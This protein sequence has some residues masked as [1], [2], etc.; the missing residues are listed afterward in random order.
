MEPDEALLGG[1]ERG[2][3]REDIERVVEN[4]RAQDGTWSAGAPASYRSVRWRPDLARSDIPAVLHVHL[5]DRLRPYMLERLTAAFEAGHEIHVALPLP[6]LYDEELLCGIHEL[7][8]Q[9]HV[10]QSETLEC[11]QSAALLTVLCDRRVQVTPKARTLLA[12]KA[13]ELSQ[14]DGSAQLRGRR[15]EAAIAFL[16]GQVDDFDVVERNLRTDT[17]ELD[18]V[19]QQRATQGRVWSGLGAPLILVEAKNWKEPV[20][21]KEASAFRVKLDGRRGVVRLGLMFGATGFTS[22]A[23]DQELRFASDE[24]TIAFVRPEELDE[25]IRAE[26]GGDEYIETLVRRAMLR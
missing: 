17:E 25:W 3:E 6:R 24:L 11:A 2:P 4:I 10:I 22:D 1:P 9:I 13:V 7:D 16:L 23:L 26:D 15:Y 19:V 21:Q 14:V 5:A 18:A 20:T 12:A 8:P